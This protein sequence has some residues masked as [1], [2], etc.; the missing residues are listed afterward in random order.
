MVFKYER[1][2]TALHFLIFHIP[3]LFFCN[4]NS[5]FVYYV[6]IVDDSA[7]R[8]SEKKTNKLTIKTI[9]FWQIKRPIRVAFRLCVPKLKWI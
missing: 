9:N 1:S 2:I 8:T 7:N 5:R 3:F 4:P 6:D